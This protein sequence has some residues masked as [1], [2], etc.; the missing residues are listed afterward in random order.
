[1]SHE[2]E[3]RSLEVALSKECANSMRILNE[4]VPALEWIQEFAR[5]NNEHG[6]V[7]TGFTHIERRAR[8]ALEAVH[9]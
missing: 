7:H 8:A 4:L 2:R 6:I 5:S 3:I 1:M 9:G